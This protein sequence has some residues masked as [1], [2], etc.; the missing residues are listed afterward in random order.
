MDRSG[1]A[2]RPAL[3]C[4]D[5][6]L[7]FCSTN[8]IESVNARIR[9]A[10]RARGHFPSEAAALNCVYRAL[11]SLDPTGTGR[12]RWTMRWKAPL[13]AFPIAFEGRLTPTSH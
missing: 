6:R 2:A 12:R 1:D 9:K 10:V 3:A 4:C 5:H 11:M 8:A 13:N 7:W